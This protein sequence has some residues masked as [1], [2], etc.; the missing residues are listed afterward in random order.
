MKIGHIN[1]KLLRQNLIDKKQNQKETVTTTSKKDRVEISTNGRK[2][3]A[4]LADKYLTQTDKNN[5]LESNHTP[6]KILIIKKRIETG[7]YEQPEIKEKIRDK[8]A[9][10]LLKNIH[11]NNEGNNSL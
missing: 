8:L 5:K 1:N 3:L 4:E 9:D 6:G 7:Y 10:K 2:L 11:R